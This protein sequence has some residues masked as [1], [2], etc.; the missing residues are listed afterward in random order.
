MYFACLKIN[1]SGSEVSMKNSTKSFVYGPYSILSKEK[2]FLQSLQNCQKGQLLENPEKMF[3]WCNILKLLHLFNHV[4]HN[5]ES[6][7]SENVCFRISRIYR[8]VLTVEHTNIGLQLD[9]AMQDCKILSLL[10]CVVTHHRSIVIWYAIVMS[11]LKTSFL[12]I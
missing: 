9:Y 6:K 2:T 5:A 7:I 4:K 11:I 3:Y 1:P 10:Y 8:C 12:H